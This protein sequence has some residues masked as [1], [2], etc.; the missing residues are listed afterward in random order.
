MASEFICICIN[1]SDEFTQEGRLKI[2]R[3]WQEICSAHL[4]ADKRKMEERRGWKH[5]R[6]TGECTWRNAARSHVGCK[7]DKA[8]TRETVSSMVYLLQDSEDVF[9]QV[10]NFNP[11]QVTTCTTWHAL[12][13][14]SPI[15]RRTATRFFGCRPGWARWL[16]M[17]F[18]F[19]PSAQSADEAGRALPPPSPSKHRPE[20][21][22]QMAKSKINHRAMV[23]LIIPS[24]SFKPNATRLGLKG[25]GTT[26][27]QQVL[28]SKME[29]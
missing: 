14:V 25:R 23:W 5:A 28:K 21:W 18:G 9:I 15:W 11:A 2:R 7:I 20:R 12:F 29:G 19:G 4:R 6:V 16:V 26:W 13:W 8:V 24:G 10:I 22:P 1:I 17:F 27:A 3:A